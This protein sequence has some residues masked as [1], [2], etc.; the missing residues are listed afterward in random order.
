MD[1]QNNIQFVN[2][3]KD[4]RNSIGSLDVDQKLQAVARSNNLHIDQ[5][6]QLSTLVDDVILGFI[7]SNLFSEHIERNLGVDKE[8]AEKITRDINNQIFA[9]IHDSLIHAYGNE[10]SDFINPEQEKVDTLEAISNP[11]ATPSRS[12][13]VSSPIG[14]TTAVSSQ[15]QTLEP[16][17]VWPL[18][19]TKVETAFPNKVTGQESEARLRRNEAGNVVS[20][21]KTTDM[22]EEKLLAPV[23]STQ[24]ETKIENKLRFSLI[25]PEIKEKIN[26]DPYKESI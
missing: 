7:D 16:A 20:T 19:P 10:T 25:P 11:Q 6:G 17:K 26:R 8:K 15:G 22:H 2:L 5:I 23:V 4:L 24:T 9:P 12:L 21:I 13:T 18:V 14:G 3:P 1:I